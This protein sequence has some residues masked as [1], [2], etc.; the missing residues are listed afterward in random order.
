MSKKGLS[1]SLSLR[2]D[3]IFEKKG[4]EI[5]RNEDNISLYN[6]YLERLSILPNETKNLFIDLTDRF[7]NITVTNVKK[8]FA[9]SYDT[10][11]RDIIDKSRKI[12]F[13]PLIIPVIN[14]KEKSKIGFFKRIFNFFFEEN[15]EDDF[16]DRPK[17]KSCDTIISLVKIEYRDIY[18]SEKFVFPESFKKFKDQF[19]DNDLLIL[20]DDFIGTGDTASEVI[21]F[22]FQYKK[23]SKKNLKI[24]TLI[25]QLEGVKR[26]EKD[27]GVNVESALIKEKALT[28]YYK[29]EEELEEK[30]LLVKKMEEKIN[31]SSDL[32]FGYKKSESLVC[33]LNKSPNNTLPVFWH[34]TKSL[35]APFPRRKIYNHARRK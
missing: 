4:W 3:S 10:I 6:N 9:D 12:Y 5:I 7:E 25:S 26:L 8:L 18:G 28:D 2:I 27:F 1:A 32:S 19:T 24:L 31:I 14:N 15:V 16:Q 33:I 22:Y 20:I 11:D 34:E 30:R 29:N 13:M 23:F 21:Q 17:Y 35:V